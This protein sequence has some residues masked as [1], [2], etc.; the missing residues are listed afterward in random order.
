MERMPCRHGQ[1]ISAGAA[2][3]IVVIV[4]GGWI[5]AFERLPPPANLNPA[6]IDLPKREPGKPWPA[7]C[8]VHR[9]CAV[10]ARKVVACARGTASR[11]WTDIAAAPARLAGTTVSVR[12]P[13]VLGPLQIAGVL[14]TE[15]DAKTGKP[16]PTCCPQST[17]AAQIFIGDSA[18]R[19]AILGQRCEGDASR[20]C[21]NVDSLGKVVVATGRLEAVTGKDPLVGLAQW[22]L[23]GDLALCLDAKTNAA[24][25]R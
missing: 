13:L 17:T 6:A 15:L 5:L 10:V 22:K 25:K 3:A 19:L 11:P 18:A 14:C 8:L 16:T 23:A 4:G 21:C 7:S 9:T 1:T 20:L 2:F 24:E 12:G